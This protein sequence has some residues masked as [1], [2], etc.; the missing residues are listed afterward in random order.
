VV[1]KLICIECPAGCTLSVEIKGSRVV[2]VTG[3]TCEK[4]EVYAQSEI[5][6]PVRIVTSTVMTTFEV[7]KLL[8]V[9]TDLPIPKA[10]I[11]DAMDAIRKIIV[12]KPLNAGD[13]VVANFLNLGINLIATRDIR[14]SV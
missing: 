2:S 5:E 9:R 10:R 8:P 3:H 4:G 11:F 12:K 6:N 1:K 7:V 14:S 13:I